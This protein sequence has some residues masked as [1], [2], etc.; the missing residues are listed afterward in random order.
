MTPESRNRTPLSKSKSPS[1]VISDKSGRTGMNKSVIKFLRKAENERQKLFEPSKDLSV[2]EFP[3]ST[4]PEHVREREDE[5]KHQ[6][7]AWMLYAQKRREY[8]ELTIT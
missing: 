2:E 7:D 1:T 8:P 6:E 3:G 4:T 5:R